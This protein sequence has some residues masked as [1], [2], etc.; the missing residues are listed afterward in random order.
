MSQQLLA[1]RPK[2]RNTKERIIDEAEALATL[3]GIEHLKLQGVAERIGIKL[4]SVY[5]HF[6]GREDILAAMTQRVNQ[7][8]NGLY[9]SENGETPAQTLRRGAQ[10]LLTL[11]GDNPAY[12][13]I[14]LRDWS[15]PP[16]YDPGGKTISQ[17]PVPALPVALQELN[18]R[19]QALLDRHRSPDLFRAGDFIAAVHGFVIISLSSLPNLEG[20][21]GRVYIDFENVKPRLDHLLDQLLG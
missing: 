14:L 9:H 1:A 16:G 15:V 20:A 5:A 6:S 3:Y 13:R 10:A 8:M 12:Y 17:H 18:Q 2:R 19:I 7:R 11:L 21:E 4:P